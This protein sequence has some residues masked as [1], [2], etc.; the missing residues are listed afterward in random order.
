M[1]TL[2]LGNANNPST[3]APAEVITAMRNRR[4]NF[5][6]HVHQRICQHDPLY[7][8]LSKE[9]MQ[10][11]SQ[12]GDTYEREIFHITTPTERDLGT[13]T[14]IRKAG[15]GYNPSADTYETMLNYGSSKQTCRLFRKGFRT[16]HFNKLDLALTFDADMQVANVKAA[17]TAH[18]M[19]IWP[20]WARQ[21]FRRSVVSRTLNKLY[22][23]YGFATEQVGGYHTGI[24]PDNF[25]T[26]EA[27]E[28]MLPGI[29]ATPS[30]TDTPATKEPNKGFEQLVFMGYQEF[31]K[32]EQLY[33]LAMVDNGYRAA[34]ALVPE[35]GVMGKKIGKY[36]FILEMFPTRFRD[37]VTV[38]GVTEPWENCIVPHVIKV[39]AQGGALAGW[40]DAANPDYYN[41][42]I[43]K[44]AEAKLYNPGSII[45][46]T[47]PGDALKGMNKEGIF[48]FPPTSYTG[49]FMPVNIPTQDDPEAENVFFIAKYMSGMMGANPGKSR[50]VLCKSA[51]PEEIGATLPIAATP[52]AFTKAV[53]AAS[54]A[55]NGHL[56]L[57]YA[58]AA[59]STLPP[60]HKLYAVRANGERVQIAAVAGTALAATAPDHWIIA[61][62]A[63][64]GNSENS[65]GFTAE[66]TLVEPAEQSDSPDTWVSIECLRDL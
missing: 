38:G 47:P 15:P 48:T 1:P 59:I 22:G 30:I 27:L 4:G 55:P 57:L 63:F 26:H 7:A 32:L 40:Q 18:T 9:K 43:A 37:P 13:W 33:R 61:S 14:E 2:T 64:A 11:P 24:A 56:L 5:S 60:L 21:Q 54:L 45:W 35:L 12:R 66:V 16:P 34:D 19:A 6:H 3:Q 31:T 29:F 25:L 62:T 46:F 51:H 10:F 8:Y 52:P 41:R 39:P 28:A 58:G 20:A 36:T 17:L 49:E 44:Y 50:C 53:Q 23:D 65:P 42:N